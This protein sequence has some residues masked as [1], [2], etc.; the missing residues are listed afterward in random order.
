MELSNDIQHS[1]CYESLRRRHN[2]H[3]G[4]SNHQPRECLL[5]LLFGR[6]SKKTS[7]LRING[8]YAGKSP[9]TGEFAAQ[10][11]SNADAPGVA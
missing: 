7:N 3:D 4:V 1:P 8:L 10:M 9:G 2:G 5:S 11:A 6:R